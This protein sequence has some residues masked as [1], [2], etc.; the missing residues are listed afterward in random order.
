M[1]LSF[2]FGK[3]AAALWFAIALTATAQ[4]QHGGVSLAQTE[5]EGLITCLHNFGSNF[6]GEV[7][8]NCKGV[9]KALMG[10]IPNVT[11]PIECTDNWND[12]RG[13]LSVDGEQQ[14]DDTARALSILI[15]DKVEGQ[16]FKAFFAAAV[17]ITGLVTAGSG[18]Y[19]Y[20]ELGG[21]RDWGKTV[22]FALFVGF[23]IFDLMG[24]WGMYSISLAGQHKN[25][26]LRRANL[27]F[28]IIGTLLLALDLKTMRGRAEHWFGITTAVESVKEIGYGMLAVVVFED[29]PQFIITIAFLADVGGTAGRSVD[30]IAV[31]SLIFSLIS[32]VGN[33]IL[34][35]RSIG[36]CKQAEETTPTQRSIEFRLGRTGRNRD[37]NSET[38]EGFG[39]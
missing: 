38:F 29:A 32:M 39:V 30:G 16:G 17:P 34:A 33:A 31:T 7:K 3:S 6:L 4:L 35:F 22:L 24:D 1:T 19:V 8:T 36:C 28:S 27:A 12:D 13:W 11:N 25:T 9:A 18:Y 20:Y 26:P 37:Q 21:D 10:A 2:V 5:A 23:R 14:C 15:A